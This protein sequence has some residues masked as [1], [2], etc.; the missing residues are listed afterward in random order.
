[1]FPSGSARS[2]GVRVQIGPAQPIEKSVTWNHRRAS[3][4]VQFLAGKHETPV[5]SDARG[6]LFRAT[7][8]RISRFFGHVA[9]ASA[10]RYEA[11]NSDRCFARSATLV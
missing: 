7:E 5:S 2:A 11:D 8:L 9:Y 1:M 10:F 4:P 6:I 3:R